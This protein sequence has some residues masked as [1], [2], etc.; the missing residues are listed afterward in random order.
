MPNGLY[1]GRVA[2]AGSRGGRDA[3]ARHAGR[4][5]RGPGPPRPVAHGVRVDVDRLAVELDLPGD[6]HALVEVASAPERRHPGRVG[7]RRSH[8][9][10]HEIGLEGSGI[11]AAHAV[12][13]QRFEQ[14]EVV[15]VGEL[16]VAEVHGVG[17]DQRQVAEVDLMERAGGRLVPHPRAAV[18]DPLVEQHLVVEPATERTLGIVERDPERLGLVR[19]VADRVEPVVV[20]CHRDDLRRAHPT[21][22]GQPRSYI[23]PDASRIIQSSR[24]SRAQWYSR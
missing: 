19:V 3:A 15:A 12:G 23:P 7:V 9:F 14:L 18:A 1:G 24:V 21:N 8:A 5:R 2:C 16:D 10:E 11:R 13:A 22:S 4:T 17:V 6:V 20:R